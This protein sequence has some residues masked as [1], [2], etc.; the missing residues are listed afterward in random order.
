MAHAFFNYS[1]LERKTSLS[2]YV[3]VKFSTIMD[4]KVKDAETLPF[5]S[6][7]KRGSFWQKCSAVSELCSFMTV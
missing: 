2:I 4:L 6:F 1:I 7:V 3:N 5:K